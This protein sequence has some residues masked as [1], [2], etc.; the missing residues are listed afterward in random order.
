M[1]YTKNALNDLLHTQ[2]LHGCV[3]PPSIPH[4]ILRISRLLVVQLIVTIASRVDV[5][6][7]HWTVGGGAVVIPTETNA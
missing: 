1:V 3:E 2:S 7:E 5:V 4:S 6:L